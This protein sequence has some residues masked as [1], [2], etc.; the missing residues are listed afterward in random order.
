MVHSDSCFCII[1]YYF[2]SFLF[3]VIFRIFNL[4][5]RRF[6]YFLF[7]LSGFGS[8]APPQEN[9]KA[10]NSSTSFYE[11]DYPH[12]GPCYLHT[13]YRNRRLQHL[14]GSSNGCTCV[15]CV[16]AAKTLNLNGP[17]YMRLQTLALSNSAM[18]FLFYSA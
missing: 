16:F 5:L 17:L 18:N 14:L 11:T 7:S 8:F 2:P 3:R 10:A 13:G 1:L 6:K 12:R 9:N 4:C 15:Q